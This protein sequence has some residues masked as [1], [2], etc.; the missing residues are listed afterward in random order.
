MREVYPN[1]L[2]HHGILG[3][4]W[5]R[6][7]FQYADGS[8]TPAGKQRYGM[9]GRDKRKLSKD[10][11]MR[12]KER[13][14]V[15]NEEARRDRF[16]AE[17]N[18]IRA[19]TEAERARTDLR[20]AKR[21]NSLAY[22]AGSKAAQAAMDRRAR[23]QAEKEAKKPLSRTAKKLVA[24]AKNSDEKTGFAKYLNDKKIEK[25]AAKLDPNEYSRAVDRINMQI[26]LEQ[27]RE[28][29]AI[30]RGKNA[31]DRAK[32]V[33]NAIGAGTD[34]W[35]ATA[36][37]I[38][39]FSGKNVPKI[40]TKYVDPLDTLKK[41]YQAE[42]AKEAAR[43]AKAGADKAE[44]TADKE[45]IDLK[46]VQAEYDKSRKAERDAAAN[47]KQAERAQEILEKLKGRRHF[48]EG[49]NVVTPDYN[50]FDSVVVKKKA[51]NQGHYDIPLKAALNDS[52]FK[53]LRRELNSGDFDIS[54]LPKKQQKLFFAM[55]NSKR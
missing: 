30:Q 23:K 18:R 13:A 43:T 38:T 46:K 37:I 2:Y 39:A 45:H 33:A 26:S 12:A 24:A 42:A 25:L 48:G 6:R 14:R 7:R 35:N 22:K 1:E 29:N 54:K 36:G 5:G 50:Q 53:R 16:V 40:N 10:A 21:E 51:K 20:D 55:L 49:P 32:N 15:K 4:K 44:Y 8:Y 3:Q 9:F 47:A 34:V 19:E 11:K 31:V 17:A 41:K 28:A 52:E 27:A